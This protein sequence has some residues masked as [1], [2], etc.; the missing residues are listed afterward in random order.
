MHEVIMTLPSHA[1]YDGALRAHPSVAAHTLASLLV[2]EVDAP[3]LL[4]ID[5]AGRGWNDTVPDGTES[6][7]N[8]GEASLVALRAKELLDA[9][10]AAEAIAVITPYAA[11]VQC[12]RE[13][14]RA[15]GV[16][17]RVEIDT[18]DAFQ[19]REKEAVLLSLVRSNHEGS[20]GFVRD[21]RR[22]NVAITRARRH[23]FVVGDGATLAVSPFVLAL[24]EH[25][26]RHDGYRSVWEWPPAMDL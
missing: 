12:I 11:Q 9:G 23:L 19:G 7:L 24:I 5:T 25:A 13:R 26:Q 16:N 3:P 4:F 18:V 10:L 2:R 1:F 21:L 22:L 14:A 8:E 17:E 20:V 6:H 15:L